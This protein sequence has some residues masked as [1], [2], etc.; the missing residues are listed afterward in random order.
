MITTQ[1]GEKIETSGGGV[2][3]AAAND[4]NLTVSDSKIE[5]GES[6]S[7]FIQIHPKLKIKLMLMYRP[8]CEQN[9]DNF[10]EIVDNYKLENCIVIGDSNFPDIEWTNQ[11]AGNTKAGSHRKSFHD[12][13]LE[14][15]NNA[16]FLQ[17][18]H[19]P[20]RKLCNIFD[21]IFVNR[22]AFNELYCNCDVMPYVSDHKMILA[23]VVP[24][25]FQ[26]THPSTEHQRKKKYN[27]KKA[28]YDL[29]EEKFQG[30]LNKVDDPNVVSVDHLW[31]ELDETKTK[32]KTV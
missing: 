21:L 10:E 4:S 2:L 15:I 8:T 28:D 30:F 14:I 17:L 18:V 31:K 20:T 32:Y 25:T 7:L 24:Q 29:I 3:I 9:L 27:F 16:D 12:K 22:S 19:E 13:A 5:C 1:Y 11:N 6:L 26:K 23:E